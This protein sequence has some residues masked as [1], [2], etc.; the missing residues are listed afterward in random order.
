MCNRLTQTFRLMCNTQELWLSSNQ[1][2]DKG[3]EAWSASLATGAMPQLE[4]LYLDENQIGDTGITALANACTGGAICRI[5]FFL[6]FVYGVR[7][8]TRHARVYRRG[9]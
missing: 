6:L 4:V 5:L 1:I 3:L 8:G 7:A 2:G 9:R